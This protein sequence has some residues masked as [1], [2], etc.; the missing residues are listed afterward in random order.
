MSWD[1]AVRLRFP[2]LNRLVR[3]QRLVYLDSA[4][5][6]LKPDVVIAAVLEHLSQGVA[7]VHRGA[8]WLSD[9]A[10]EKFER[11]RELAA[12]FVGAGDKSEII[13]TR[14][15][16]EG[17]NLIAATLGRKIV[18]PDDEI[19]LSQMEHHSNIVPWQMLA[20]ERGAKVR[21]AKVK[22]DGS[23]DQDDFRACLNPRTRFVSLVHL[24][25]ALGTINPVAGLFAMAR[26]RGAVCVLDAAQSAS[27]LKIDVRALNCDFAAWS[28]HKM[29]GPTGVGALW[30]RR[31][32]L[33]GMPPYQGGGSMIGEVSETDVTF[34]PP[35]HRFEAGTPAVAEV[36]GFG[37]AIEFVQS[38]GFENIQRHEREVLTFAEEELRAVGD[39]RRIGTAPERGHV[40]SFL[41][42]DQHPADVGAILDEQGVAIRAG[43]HCC[44]PLM[45]RFGIPG[46][47]RASFS[48]YT[49]EQDVRDFIRAVRKAKD[50]L[51]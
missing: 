36:I 43:H 13:F 49:S 48:I 16:T 19:L 3:D 6:T 33:N 31:E 40:L 50:M 30:G 18:G 11:A 8:H 7:N 21:F 42:G 25:N 12:G 44:Q 15:T 28:A 45:K 32:I 22:D 37:A 26:E 9:A 41:L 27:L 23:I 35:P 29:F 20:R 10:T 2:Q 34:L 46:T 4:A 39:I 17:V 38:L 14:G 47:N 1:R 5:T 24:S 51:L